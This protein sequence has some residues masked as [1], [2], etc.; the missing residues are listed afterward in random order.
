M[1][2]GSNI[3]LFLLLL[4]FA[5]QAAAIPVGS[6]PTLSSSEPA[7]IHS[8][9]HPQNYKIPYQ[10]RLLVEETEADPLEF[11]ETS[12]FQP[13]SS[14]P[15]PLLSGLSATTF[16]QQKRLFLQITALCFARLYLFYHQIKVGTSSL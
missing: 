9:K 7:R 3:L 12:S 2:A 6:R 4:I 14:F 15:F 5:Q 11:K 1:K 13:F 8:R 10:H 16:L